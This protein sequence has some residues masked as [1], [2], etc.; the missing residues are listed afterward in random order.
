MEANFP[1]FLSFFFSLQAFCSNNSLALS[2]KIFSQMEG[3]ILFRVLKAC[4][5]YS[6]KMAMTVYQ[7]DRLLRLLPKMLFKFPRM[8]STISFC[9]F[10]KQMA[11]LPRKLWDA[12][13]YHFYISRMSLQE[14]CRKQGQ[15]E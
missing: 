6:Y 11:L 4:Y 14:A 1:S 8:F 13:P 7:T 10:S 9:L 3:R 15:C 2:S 12:V 5:K